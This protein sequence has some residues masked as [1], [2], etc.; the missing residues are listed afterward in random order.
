MM[1]KNGDTVLFQGD[2]ITDAGRGNG[3]GSGYPFYISTIFKTKYPDL[4]VNFINRGISGNRAEDLANRWQRDCLDLKPTWTSILIGINDVWRQM[5]GVMTVTVE[6][7]Y[8]HYRKILEQSKAAGQKII[9]LE[10]FL[11]HCG[12]ANDGWYP[13]LDPKIEACRSLAREFADVYIPLGGMFT[14]QSLKKEP[15]FWAG[16]GVH[17]SSEG[18][19]F[20]AMEWLKS[21]EAYYA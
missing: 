7:F 5:E 17:P 21:M 15:A 1:L 6:A 2:S 12:V 14:A 11:L 18:H 8:S 9:I 19:M 20:I 4:N 3:M 16:D 10:P 13:I